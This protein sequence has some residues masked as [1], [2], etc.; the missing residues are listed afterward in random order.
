MDF[1]RSRPHGRGREDELHDLIQYAGAN[2]VDANE[3]RGGDRLLDSGEL[4]KVDV[5]VDA[6]LGTGAA[7]SPRG[8]MGTAIDFANRTTA[9]RIAIDI[10]T[11]LDAGTG[12]SSSSTFKADVTLTFVAPKIGFDSPNAKECIGHVVV[13]PI[14]VPPEVIEMTEVQ[15]A[16]KGEKANR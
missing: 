10:P 2:P 1:R 13:L 3:L 5:I 8:M 16:P 15:G 12:E 9:K 11:G 6:M 4:A 7:G 14:G